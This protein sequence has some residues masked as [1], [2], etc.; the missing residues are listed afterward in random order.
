MFVTEYIHMYAE[1][2]LIKYK[3]WKFHTE[4]FICGS[5]AES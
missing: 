5:P 4:H 3:K 2:Y 1:K